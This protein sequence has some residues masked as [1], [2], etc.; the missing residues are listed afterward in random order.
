VELAE[1]R[2]REEALRRALV[3]AE[4]RAVEAGAAHPLQP[5]TPAAGPPPGS[6]ERRRPPVVRPADPP[7]PRKERVPVSVGAPDPER[8]SPPSDLRRAVFASLTELA[9]DGD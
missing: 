4:N 8:K 9:G 6:V 7:P 2:E 3:E 5:A 1:R